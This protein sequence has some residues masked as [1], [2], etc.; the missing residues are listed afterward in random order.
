MR[1]ARFAAVAAILAVAAATAIAAP[2]S[3]IPPADFADFAY[4]QNLGAPLPLDTMLRGPDGQP[5]ALRS[6]FGTAPVLIDFEYDRCT[7]LCGVMLD[8]VIAALAAAHLRPGRDYRVAAIDIDPATTT[9]DAGAFAHEHGADGPG[10]TVLT[11]APS[12]IRGI[13]DA[14]GFPYR[15]DAA[16]G[17]FAHPAGI[18]IA[19]PDGHIARYLL[20]LSWRPF[21][22]RLA[23]IEAAGGGVAAPAEQ[24]LLFCYCYD[25][26]SGQYDLAVAKLLEIVGAVT[27]LGLGTI[28]FLAARRVG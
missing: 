8:Q 3:T 20:G 22:L 25:P 23:L 24:V 19:T 2:R 15:R 12:A 11:G 5:V 26:Q 27:L 28:V 10:V 14:A 17:Q 16:T 13:A 6:L 1:P 9:R 18:V 21:D 4:R 7:T